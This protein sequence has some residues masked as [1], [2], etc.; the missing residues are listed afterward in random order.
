MATKRELLAAEDA[1]WNEYH[2]VLESLAPD[3][4]E[5][6][7]YYA[8]GW[9]AKDLEAYIGSWQAEACQILL[10]LRYD[11]YRK[12]DLDVDSM[13]QTF[14]EANKDLPLAVVRA[15]A[16]AARTRMLTVFNDL[17][18]VAPLAEEWFVE[19]GAEHYREHL[20]RLVA[21]RGVFRS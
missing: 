16:W 4:L 9:S 18:E 17:P 12:A 15:E 6:P 10:Q 3:Q 13:N 7:G 5:V 8:E 20:P 1:G 11:T 14:Y 21:W 19:S 2:G